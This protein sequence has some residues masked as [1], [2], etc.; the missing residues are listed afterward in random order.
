LRRLDHAARRGCGAR[1]HSGVTPL[2]AWIMPRGGDVELSTHSSDSE[3]DG[4]SGGRSLYSWGSSKSNRFPL[5]PMD[6]E[7]YRMILELSIDSE[8]DATPATQSTDATR[9]NLLR[10]KHMVRKVKGKVLSKVK[11]PIALMRREW[12]M[13]VNNKEAMYDDA[14]LRLRQDM[15]A[16]KVRWYGCWRRDLWYFLRN[17]HPV[18]SV[19]Y[20]HPL[21]PVSRKARW[22]AYFLQMLFVLAIATALSEA[23]RCFECDIGFCTRE[24]YNSCFLATVAGLKPAAHLLEDYPVVTKNFCCVCECMGMLWCFRI[25][26]KDLGGMIYA[27]ATNCTFTIFIFQMI[28]CSKAQLLDTRR[29]EIRSMIGKLIVLG[30][31]FWLFTFLPLL[32][33]WV[34]FKHMG[35][36]L[37]CNFVV[38][39][40]GSWLTVTLINVTAFSAFWRNEAAKV[41]MEP[42]PYHITA[43]QFND[44]ID[45]NW[46]ELVEGD[47]GEME[48]E[49]GYEQFGR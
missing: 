49:E 3:T 30:I 32:F 36:T 14:S 37:F 22:F 16:G 9:G 42:S 2:R 45:A 41:G 13:V 11:R 33:F 12:D 46:D 15:A 5:D 47:L 40:L 29:R 10:A 24:N 31:A 6:A 43:E 26:G 39:K 7:T 8:E 44:F 17:T 21:H 20:S 18:V 48:E 28:M 23:R 35:L 1:V 38:G 19:C 34:N 4:S 25:F 27:I